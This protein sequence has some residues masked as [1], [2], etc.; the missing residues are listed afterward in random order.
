MNDIKQIELNKSRSYSAC[1]SEAFGTFAHNIKTI[2]MHTWVYALILGVVSSLYIGSALDLMTQQPTGLNIC[3]MGLWM[4]LTLVATVALYARVSMLIN[5]QKMVWNVKRTARIA[6]TAVIFSIVLGVIIGLTTTMT[7]APAKAIPDQHGL[8]MAEIVI[9]IV[10]LIICLLVMPYTYVFAKYL[11]EP[12]TK[13]RKLV[14]KGYKTGLKHWGFIFTTV[15]LTQLCMAICSVI[16]ALPAVII[17]SAKLASINGVATF[18]D[19]TGL[20]SS[21]GAMQFALFTLAGLIWSFINIPVLF[22]H[23]FIYGSVET[24]EKEKKDFLNQQLSTINEMKPS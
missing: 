20:P 12:H 3:L 9:N 17:I 19:P 24:R 10:V 16:I 11:M 8:P 5:R 14:F 22:V 23:F 21:F 4:I 13:L 7:Q 6:A 2:F 15:F 18:G 1:I